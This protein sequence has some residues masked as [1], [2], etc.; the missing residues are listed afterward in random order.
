MLAFPKPKD[1]GTVRKKRTEKW[2]QKWTE[3]ILYNAKKYI[4]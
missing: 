4:I 1:K 2:T 3:R